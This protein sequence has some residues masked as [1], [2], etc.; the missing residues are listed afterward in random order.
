MRRG[1]REA[2]IDLDE[3]SA[4]PRDPMLLVAVRNLLHDR[5]RLAAAL[6]GVAFAV[7]LVTYQIGLL[8]RFLRNASAIIDRA[9]APIWITSPSVTNFE[10]GS[11]LEE[12]VYAQVLAVPGIARVERLAFV[13]A[14]FRM[15]TGSYEGV[16][17]LG[18]DLSKEPRVPWE[19]HH[20]S[21]DDLKDPEAIA[22]DDTDLEKLG[23]PRIGEYVEINDR[24]AKVVAYT[25]EHRSFIAS[26]FIFTSLENA[27]RIVDR[28][29]PGSFT[30]LLVTPAREADT[31]EVLAAL[32]RIPGVDVLRAGE[33]A[34]RSRRYW[35][36][37][38]GAGFAIGVSTLLGFVVGTVIVGQ[39]IYSSTMD[40]LKEF[41]T[42]KAIGASNPDLYRL[43]V[44]QALI[45]AAAG[46]VLG[47]AASAVVAR[48][49][50]RTAASAL[51]SGPL[52][53]GMLVVTTAM[54]VTASFLS[55][56]RITRL[57]PAMVFKG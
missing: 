51:I 45:Y 15:P 38:T 30:Y 16:Q 36:F 35:I 44:W 46:Y 32:R 26:P 27:W 13:F 47:M 9:G 39:T 19:F 37:R 14:R 11:I 50:S 52:V 10:Y 55:I 18:I 31:D 22:V 34:A 7:V 23:R 3:A 40:R 17:L 6:M 25:H 57:E 4:A 8:H 54:C 49:A 53:A 56:A 48:F 28:V 43:I 42:L 12:R 21:I 41:G 1:A 20:G 2:P 24:R 5:M 33:L 29:D